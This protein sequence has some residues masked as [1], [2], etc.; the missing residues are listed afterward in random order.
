MVR[1]LGAAL[2]AA[3]Q[4]ASIRVLV[5]RGDGGNF[6]AGGD[7]GAMTETG[8]TDS[9]GDPLLAVSRAFGALCAAFWKSSIATVAAVEG[10]ALGGGVGLVAAC[11][12]ALAHS[13]ARFSLPETGLGIVPAQ[14]LPFVLD[15]IGPGQA[16]RLVVTG[17]MVNAEEA[18]AIG[19]VHEVAEDLDTAL[20]ATLERVLASAPG[21]IAASKALLRQASH[22]AA[23]QLVEPAAQIFAD[24]V[25]GTEGLEGIRAFMERRRPS[26]R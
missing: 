12:I 26:W 11:D 23:D 5:L 16:R 18:L 9:K 25:R 20:A 17:G 15:R 10:S 4:D 6:C 1:E 8:A 3:E 22:V 21:A 13:G 14:I 7:L 19:L 24:S 2:V